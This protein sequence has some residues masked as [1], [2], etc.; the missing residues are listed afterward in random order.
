MLIPSKH[1]GKRIQK[2]NKPQSEAKRAK[3]IRMNVHFV[4]NMLFVIVILAINYIGQDS[5]IDAI[6]KVA[7]YTYGPLLGMFAFGLFTKTQIKDRY[8]P[9][10]AVIAPFLCYGLEYIL[11]HTLNYKVGYEI[12][13][14]NGLLTFI[15][16]WTLRKEKNI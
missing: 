6:Y 16:L 5:I 11:L 13:M 9:Y 12:L 8:V 14:L 7:S 10:V 2:K 15:G 3:K 1:Q 4:V